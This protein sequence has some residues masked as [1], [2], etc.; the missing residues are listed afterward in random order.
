MT[1]ARPKGWGRAYTIG[2]CNDCGGAKYP[3]AIYA[4]QK[5]RDRPL[6]HA[7]CPKH[8]TPLAQTTWP[9]DNARVRYDPSPVFFD[10]DKIRGVKAKVTF[11]DEVRS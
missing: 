9:Q 2:R 10:P 11:V 4:W 5:H 1:G 6:K 7:H 8:R 3:Y